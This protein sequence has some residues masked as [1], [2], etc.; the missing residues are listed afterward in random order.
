MQIK[1]IVVV[2]VVA[3]AYHGICCNHYFKQ[4]DNVSK[5]SWLTYL[6]LPCCLLNSQ[7]I[8]LSELIHVLK[9]VTVVT[10]EHLNLSTIFVVNSFLIAKVTPEWR[11]NPGFGTQKKCPF[12]CGDRLCPF[13]RGNKNKD[14]VNIFPGPNFVS[15]EW[16]CPLNRGVLEE[17]S[18]LR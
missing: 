16:R 18:H 9:V 6:S 12:S 4:L 14:Y 13:Y 5:K 2:V 10:S 17:R 11:V 7:Y 1:L 15:P 3:Y 8:D